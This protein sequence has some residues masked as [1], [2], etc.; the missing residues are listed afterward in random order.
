MIGQAMD[1]TEESLLFCN[2]YQGAGPSPKQ[3]RTMLLNSGTEQLALKGL[4]NMKIQ[5]RIELESATAAELW[6]LHFNSSQES[7]FLY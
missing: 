6:N 2:Q 1:D 4:V 5:E 3:K 7:L